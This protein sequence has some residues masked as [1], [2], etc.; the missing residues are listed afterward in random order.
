[1]QISNK[2]FVVTGGASGLG[3]ASAEAILAAGGNV[4]LLDV[5]TLR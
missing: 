4:V 2:T 1:M 3:R 5:S